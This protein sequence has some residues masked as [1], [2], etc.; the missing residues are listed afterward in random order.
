VT[1]A[2]FWARQLGGQAPPPH[3]QQAPPAASGAWWGPTPASP[4]I[5]V[6]P[7]SGGQPGQYQE[8]GQPTYEDLKRMNASDMT[9][10]Q[11]ELLAQY[12]LEAG[13]YNNHCPNCQSDNFIPQGTRVSTGTG[14]IKMGTD[15]CFECGAS[16]ST[17]TGS[18][19][20]AVG[21]TGSKGNSQHTRQTANGGE[22]GGNYGRHHSEIPQ[23]YLP[24]GPQ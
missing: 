10:E 11:M 16:S 9:Q 22:S 24:R 4:H 7:P 12:E 23:N 21:V 8:P 1:S 14:T 15:K 3:I 17:L 5:Q 20:P 18:P 6:P 19:E 13:K 2:D